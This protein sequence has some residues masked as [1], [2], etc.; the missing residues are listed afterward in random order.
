GAAWTQNSQIA[1]FSSLALTTEPDGIEFRFGAALLNRRLRDLRAS[2]HMDLLLQELQSAL[3][4]VP[5]SDSKTR[6]LLSLYGRPHPELSGVL[7]ATDLR[8]V[9]PLAESD[10]MQPW[11]KLQIVSGMYHVYWPQFRGVCDAIWT[12][13]PGG[14]RLHAFMS[15]FQGMRFV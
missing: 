11:I 7:T 8:F 1:L 2:G 10:Q 9:A 13:A 14:G 5:S 6:L 12:Q 4:A 3:G 15:L